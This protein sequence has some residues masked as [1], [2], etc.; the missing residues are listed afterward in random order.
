[1]A[2]N[3][4]IMLPVS[5]IARYSLSAY[6]KVTARSSLSVAVNTTIG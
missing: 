6:F 2:L 4:V 3:R 5:K 1:M